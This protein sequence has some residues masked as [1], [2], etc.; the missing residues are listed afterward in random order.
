MSRFVNLA[1]LSSG[2]NRTTIVG[3]TM[4]SPRQSQGTV[5]M[6]LTIPTT[7]TRTPTALNTITS[8]GFGSFAT[9]ANVAG[10]RLYVT[11][12]NGGTDILGLR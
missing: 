3:T 5:V 6:R 12:L 1:A 9:A 4:L 7:G 10:D 2:Q 11:N 8:F